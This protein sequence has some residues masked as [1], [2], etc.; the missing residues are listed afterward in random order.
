MC[1]APQ[2]VRRASEFSQVGSPL[3]STRPCRKYAP[4]APPRYSCTHS[5]AQF[6]LKQLCGA[7]TRSRA[8]RQKLRSRAHHTQ[9]AMVQQRGDD[10]ARATG[11]CKSLL[12]GAIRTD[13][14]QPCCTTRT[15]AHGT[16]SPS[17][18]PCC[19]RQFPGATCGGSAGR[20]AST[21]VCSWREK[22]LA[23]FRACALSVARLRSHARALACGRNAGSN[24]MPSTGT[25]GVT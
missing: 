5:V 7:A 12:D 15:P 10:A 21:D 19:S 14:L 16:C 6:G 23:S 24:N 17:A 1:H 25:E 20:Q 3:F 22:N 18:H 8:R 2:F 11:G 9:L 13:N 4:S